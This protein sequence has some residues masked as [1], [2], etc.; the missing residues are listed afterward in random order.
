MQPYGQP[1]AT[2]TVL[3]NRYRI[4]TLLGEG[5]MSRVY[6]ADAIRLGTR[7]A[8]NSSARRKSS[9]VSRTRTCRALPT[10]SQMPRR[11]ASTW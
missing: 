9:R 4:I 7:V 2:G 5:G 11:D 1:L 8:V 3:E 10:I 6:L